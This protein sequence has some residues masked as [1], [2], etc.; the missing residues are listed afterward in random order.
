M[1][2]VQVFLKIVGCFYMV[3]ILV[4]EKHG[5]D[6]VLVKVITTVMVLRHLMCTHLTNFE[7]VGVHGHR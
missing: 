5:L 2:Q 6:L 3:C 1:E 4:F 7:F